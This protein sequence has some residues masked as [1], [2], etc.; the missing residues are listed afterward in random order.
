MVALAA[1]ETP[2]VPAPAEDP[3]DGDERKEKV[4]AMREKIETLKQKIGLH[5]RGGWPRMEGGGGGG[6]KRQHYN[7]HHVGA[8]NTTRLS[9]AVML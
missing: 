9:V 5:S 3:H 1:T 6:S 8:T 2:T 4:G 7:S